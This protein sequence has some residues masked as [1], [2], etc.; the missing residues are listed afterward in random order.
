VSAPEGNDRLL[1]FDCHEAWVYQLRVLP[2]TMDVVVGLKGRHTDGW[3]EAM[4][5][6]PP[7]ARIVRLADVIVSVPSYYCIVAHNLTD[8]LDAKPLLGPRLFVIHQTLE[9]TMREQRSV[10]PPEELRRAVA[11]Y[12]ATIGGHVMAV[13]ALKGRSWG[14]NG[15]VVPF[16]ADPADYPAYEGDVPRGLRIANDIR[17]KAN[18]LMWD[19]HERAFAGIPIT[20]LGRNHDMPGVKPARNWTELKEVLSHHRFFVHTASPELEDGYNMATLEAMAAGLPVLG[21]RHP[22][23]PIEHGVSG[24]LSDDPAELRDCA[25]RLLEDR[26]LAFRMGQE[27]QKVLLKTFPVERFRAGLLASIKTARDKWLQRSI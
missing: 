18:T 14:F 25:R 1:V 27:A 21:N 2:H 7:N 5:P 15:D 10:T 24:F 12:I 4:R 8:L 17:A 19:F 13:S 11:Q 26:A 9:S 6:V 16:S 23:S 20:L 22:T 3:D